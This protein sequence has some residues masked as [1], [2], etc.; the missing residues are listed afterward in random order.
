MEYPN[1]KE[2]AKYLMAKDNKQSP[3]EKSISVSTSRKQNFMA[4]REKRK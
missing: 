3:A 1:I 4:L 2:L